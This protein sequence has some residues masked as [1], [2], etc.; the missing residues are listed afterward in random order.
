MRAQRSTQNAI[1]VPLKMV[2]GNKFGRYPKISSEET[3]NMIVADNALVP[4]AGYQFRLAIGGNGR[5][6]YS[7]TVSGNMYAVSDNRILQINSVFGSLIVGNI[8]SSSGDVYI[9]EDT[10]GNV[11]F[12]D[13][14]NVY[15]YN[16]KTPAGLYIATVPQGTLPTYVAFQDGRFIITDTVN[17]R[18]LL[19]DPSQSTITF[20]GTAP[21]VGLFQTIADAPIALIP[22]QSQ[23]NLL[24]VMGSS[25]AE[26]WY[27]RGLALFPYQ[28][29]TS[30]NI[31]YGVTNP[32]TID[33]IDNMVVWCAS[34]NRSGITIMATRGDSPEQISTDGI[35]Y[36]LAHLAEP[37]KSYGF[38]FKQD[39]HIIYVVTFYGAKDNISLAYDFQTKLFFTITDEFMNYHIAKKVVLFNG[40]YYFISIND[41]NLY[42]LS[43]N[44]TNYQYQNKTVEIPRVR[45][46]PTFRQD[47]GTPFITQSVAFPIEQG[48]DPFN[49]QVSNNGINS[50][51]IVKAGSGYT[52]ASVLIQ[53]DGT[54][55]TATAIIVAGGIN[56]I[57]IGNP[58]IGYTWASATITG[59][60]IGATA[61]VEAGM[62][63]PR[64]D[65]SISDDGG[66]TFGNFDG[67]QMNLIAN[68][69]NRFVYYG[70]GYNNEITPQFRFFGLGRFVVFDG[71]MN[72]FQ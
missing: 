41:G 1:E 15:I 6:L 45:V 12:C 14:K 43:S 29:N 58:G 4:F 28:K 57:V 3:F 20:P 17:G 50:I 48:N 36:E 19:S 2:G 61:T 9:A 22:F 65:L 40:E 31:P 27:D 7:S 23:G 52:H 18:W 63:V 49:D 71:V 68:R 26:P 64:V 67:M 53:G 72:I 62:Y 44:F 66:D 69:R 56:S 30:F 34:N 11:A 13:G 32:A 55:A 70:L 54:G 46:C 60:G 16:Y 25:L 37:K 10:K 38:L 59:D 47:N 8:Q 51:T 42:Q 5:G 33:S 21:F 35:N 24:Y 39:G